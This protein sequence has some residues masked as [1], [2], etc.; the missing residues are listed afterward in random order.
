M[1]LLNIRLFVFFVVI[2]PVAAAA[3]AVGFGMVFAK[4]L[5]INFVCTFDEEI[6]HSLLHYV[7]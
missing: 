6:K 1:E 5:L 4:L 7:V 3:A 2:V